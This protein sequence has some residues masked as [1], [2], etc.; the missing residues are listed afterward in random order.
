MECPFPGMDPYLESPF[1]WE[2]VQLQIVARLPEVFHPDLP[3]D[4]Y[5]SIEPRVYQTFRDK[6]LVE[7]QYDYEDQL[8]ALIRERG[9]EVKGW[10]RPPLSKIDA[11]DEVKERYAE[12]WDART[13]KRVTV[14]EILSLAGKLTVPGRKEYLKWREKML[15]SDENFVE[16]DLL[17]WGDRMPGCSSQPPS[18]YGAMVSRVGRRPEFEWIGFDLKDP[19]PSIPIPL[20]EDDPDLQLDLRPLLVSIY[21]V[22]RVWHRTHYSDPLVPPLP[23]DEEVWMDLLLREKGLR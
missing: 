9:G 17:R 14:V 10:D 8:H 19:I 6:V 1:L 4:Y 18:D 20:R 13:H 5:Q 11:P 22:G 21:E 23:A 16:I 15:A 12:I 2:G 7:L 3:D